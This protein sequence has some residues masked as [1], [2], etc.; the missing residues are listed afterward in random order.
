MG[1]ATVSSDT[2]SANI[3]R[4]ALSNIGSEK[5]LTLLSILYISLSGVNLSPF[6]K[7][8]YLSLPPHPPFLII[9]EVSPLQKK[10]SL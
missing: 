8:V 7:D 3:R 1:G 10:Y 2:L 6:L 5:H 4:L 9:E